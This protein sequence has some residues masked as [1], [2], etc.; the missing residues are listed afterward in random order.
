MQKK[1]RRLHGS[2]GSNGP[3]KHEGTRKA[4]HYTHERL[5]RFVGWRQV[6]VPFRQSSPR[7]NAV[8]EKSLLAHH[9]S[10]QEN[11][12]AFEARGLSRRDNGT[13]RANL[14]GKQRRMRTRADVVCA[15]TGK[16][17]VIRA[18]AFRDIPDL[19]RPGVGPIT[20]RAVQYAIRTPESKKP[21]SLNRAF[22]LN[23]LGWLMGLE[24]TTTGITILDSTN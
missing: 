10:R 1:S 17:E 4:I 12:S 15:T 24:P 3:A 11:G 19:R 14:S 8:N 13:A 5:L 23:S 7:W 22:C 2:S 6:P 16:R 9:A 18:R 20:G 21:G